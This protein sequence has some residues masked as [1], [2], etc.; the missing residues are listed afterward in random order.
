MAAPAPIPVS[1]MIPVPDSMFRKEPPTETFVWDRSICLSWG[2]QACTRCFGLG[3]NT[4]ARCKTT[5]PCECVL[6]RIFRACYGKFRRIQ[7]RQILAQPR[8]A[9]RF[10]LTWSRPREEFCADFLLI[11]KRKLTTDE[12]KIFRLH[13]LLGG[14]WRIGRILLHIDRGN[15]FHAVYRIERKLGRAYAET[16][17]YG[18]FPIGD[19]FYTQNDLHV[20]KRFRNVD[21]GTRPYAGEG[22]IDSEFQVDRY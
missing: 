17:P 15:F 6:R 13:W 14:D 12:W 3:V 1:S 20:S 11:A 8:A 7:T 21:G 2:N 18:I 5:Q 19:Y 4:N 9:S 22:E 10:G 16:K